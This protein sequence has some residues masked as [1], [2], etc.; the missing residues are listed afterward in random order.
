MPMRSYLMHP[1]AALK[2]LYW[3]YKYLMHPI[4]GILS[5][6]LRFDNSPYYYALIRSEKKVTDALCWNKLDSI[7]KVTFPIQKCIQHS[8]SDL[9]R[10]LIVWY[11][12][13]KAISQEVTFH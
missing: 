1:I 12:L 2:V 8:G 5:Q 4:P 11:L 9:S 13:G 10:P 6:I 3:S 7:F